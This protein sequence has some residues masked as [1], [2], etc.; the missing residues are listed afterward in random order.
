MEFCVKII[1]LLVTSFP[2]LSCEDSEKPVVCSVIQGLQGFIGKDGRDGLPGP[3]GDPGSPG[4]T[5]SQGIKG[6]RG[7]S[8]KA[9]PQGQKGEKGDK[10]INGSPGSLGLKGEK[11]EPGISGQKGDKG[12]SSAISALQ[13]K[14]SSIEEQLQSLQ[15]IVATQKKALLFTK[16]TS[17]GTKLFLT[18]SETHTYDASKA[19][20]NKAGG[21]IA[22][23][24]NAEENQAV[25]QIVHNNNAF[26]G[27]NDLETEGVFKS[28]NGQKITYSNWN[29]KEPNQHGN[30]DC[31]EILSGGKWNDVPCD[32][33]RL[34]ICEFSS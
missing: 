22:S 1:I 21:H 8:G 5:G 3:K 24:Q 33:K 32:L 4:Q 2:L 13:Q 17:S 29:P 15:K 16:G 10:G 9:G 26:L 11:G 20:C 19:I 30:E 27:I 12:D 34:L 25:A 14:L 7:Y 23:P 28:P 6:D 31:V 18:N